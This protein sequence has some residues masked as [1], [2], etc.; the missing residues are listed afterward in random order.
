MNKKFTNLQYKYNIDTIN[1]QK[2]F[3]SLQHKYDVDIDIMNKKFTNLQYGHGIL[4]NKFDILMEQLSNIAKAG[5]IK[6]PLKMIRAYK[7]LLSLY[8]QYKK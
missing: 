5:T 4:N 1:A 8:R 6:N 3:N 2:K 7:N